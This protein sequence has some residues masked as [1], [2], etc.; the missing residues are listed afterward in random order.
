MTALTQIH[1]DRI[2]AILR[3]IAPQNVLPVAMALYKGGIRCIEVTLNSPDALQVIESL[4]LAMEGRMLIGA[5]T[6]LNAAAASDA[7]SA[8]AS[9]II[10]PIT[11]QETIDTAKGL[12][13]VS[14][15]GAFTPTEIVKAFTGGGDIIKVF[16]ASA[17]PGYIREILAPLPHIP[18]M[19]TGGVNTGNINE[20][21][22]AGGVA[23]GVGKA[24]VDAGKQANEGFLREIKENAQKFISAM[25]TV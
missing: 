20:F 13:A 14:I 18:L 10:S 7:I 19:P 9:F 2:I 24:L 1:T 3:G 16:P 5:G 15:P 11:D 4:V 23:F 12:G 22:K 25:N 6:V 8:G 21:K 17:G